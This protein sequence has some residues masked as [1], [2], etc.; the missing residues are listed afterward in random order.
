MN[1]TWDFYSSR[2]RITLENFLK[3]VTSLSKALEKFNE[4]EIIPPDDLDEFFKKNEKVKE[5]K[6][7][8][9]VTSPIKKPSPKK[10]PVSTK[11]KTD[12]NPYFR[13]VLKKEEK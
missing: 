11:K 8:A 10:K 5:V 2:K 6:P 9:T 12:K 7:V 3:D 13:K 1:L 4:Y